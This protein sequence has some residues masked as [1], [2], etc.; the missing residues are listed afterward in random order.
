M[1]EKPFFVNLTRFIINNQN[2]CRNI[3]IRNVRTPICMHY[4][5]SILLHFVF[6]S[7]EVSDALLTVKKEHTKTILS[8]L[9][10][11]NFFLKI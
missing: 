4:V 7:D 2:S 6:F 10:F 1:G 11:F 3:Q 8:I 9:Q 5:F